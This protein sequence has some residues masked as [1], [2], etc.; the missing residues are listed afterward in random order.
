MPRFPVLPQRTSA[1]A[2]F[3]NTPRAQATHFGAGISRN[4]AELGAEAVDLGQVI[5]QREDRQVIQQIAHFDLELA[6]E[7]AASDAQA[8]PG[9]ESDARITRHQS[10]FETGAQRLVQGYEGQGLEEVV[11]EAVQVRR[12]SWS[13]TLLA[14][15]AQVRAGK[16]LQ[17]VASLLDNLSGGIV[18][19]PSQFYTASQE[20]FGDETLGEAGV[21]S[22]LGLRPEALAAWQKHALV[23]LL[24][25][26][27]KGDPAGLLAEL[28][29]ERWQGI[30]SED[31]RTRLREDAAEARQRRDSKDAIKLEQERIGRAQ[32]LSRDIGANAAGLSD[33]RQAEEAGL[34]S[35]MQGEALRGELEQARIARVAQQV[36]GDELAITLSTGTGFNA[37]S[38]QHRQAA[39]DFYETTFRQ[40]VREGADD[41]TRE[42]I[43]DAVGKTGY[44]PKA[45]RQDLNG[46]L[47]G[48]DEAGQVQAAELYGS[49][50]VAAPDAMT[51]SVDLEASAWGGVLNRWRGMG[52]EPADAL[53]RAKAEFP[54]DGA[55][56]ALSDEDTAAFQRDLRKRLGGTAAGQVVGGL[57][58]GF[59]KRYLE[60]LAA[61]LP[62]DQARALV[63]RDI[64]RAF[65]R[66]DAIDA[67]LAD[68]GFVWREQDGKRV[69]VA[70]EARLEKAAVPLAAAG[71]GLALLMGTAA[72][73]SYG[74]QTSRDFGFDASDALQDLSDL[75]NSASLESKILMFD[76]MPFMG[77]W[78]DQVAVELDDGDKILAHVV[79]YD[80][81]IKARTLEGRAPEGVYE[82]TQ[83]FDWREDG[84]VTR[85]IRLKDDPPAGRHL[86][87]SNSAEGTGAEGSAEGSGDDSKTPAE[88]KEKKSGKTA[89]DSGKSEPHGDGGRALEKIKPQIELLQQQLK[90]AKTR[91]E[92]V[93]LRN[94]IENIEKD[95]RRKRKGV[96]HGKRGQ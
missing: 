5:K 38:P 27:A 15:E 92:K 83:F 16:K 46:K 77:E 85:R 29:T 9:E 87:A 2:A 64:G 81:Q 44:V 35:G 12:E 75:L 58:A 82:V 19:D 23:R 74:I 1:P 26:Q 73:L 84:Y 91:R 39:D 53:H 96:T 62:V 21:L 88:T 45:L 41:P 93:K 34:L 72:A 60:S 32:E 47:L 80:D 22:G 59:D 65:V 66:W 95:A 94:R 8:P 90:D 68:A 78:F 86:S 56:N 36:A 48:S 49:L 50:R 69:L 18:E 13:R 33:I 42:R 70:T 17:D 71:A 76:A 63:R 3:S 40:A 43:A 25:A 89:Q 31:D 24:D 37:E 6:K 79:G 20:L 10:L 54:R 61:G 7:R 4:L 28:E 55:H 57:L 52:L 14:A 51:L 11:R 30:L 67:Q